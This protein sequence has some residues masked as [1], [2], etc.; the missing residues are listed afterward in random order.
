MECELVLRRGPRAVE[1]SHAGHADPVVATSRGEVRL[2]PRAREE[3]ELKADGDGDLDVREDP[4]PGALD[5]LAAVGEGPLEADRAGQPV[6]QVEPR[7]DEGRGRVRSL[8]G[9]DGGAD[10]RTGVRPRL[11]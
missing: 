1:L 6:T 11:G 4:F 10:A 3:E 7:A 5:R 9:G 8:A 2:H